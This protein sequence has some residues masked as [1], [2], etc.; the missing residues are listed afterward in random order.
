MR[1]S[2]DAIPIKTHDEP[3]EE[4]G[5]ETHTFGIQDLNREA[6]V[7][8]TDITEYNVNVFDFGRHCSFNL[9]CRNLLFGKVRPNLTISST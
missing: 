5:I 3:M 8:G 2:R 1:V 6:R 4:E 9:G 7:I